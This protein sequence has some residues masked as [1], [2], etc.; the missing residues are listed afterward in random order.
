ME[1]IYAIAPHKNP[2][3][4]FSLQAT[5]PQHPGLAGYEQHGYAI[6]LRQSH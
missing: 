3:V 1:I 4:N 2:K 5:P 6:G